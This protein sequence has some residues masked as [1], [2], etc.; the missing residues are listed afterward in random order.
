MIEAI[1]YCAI[2]FL[3][4]TLLA[5]L[6][7]PAVWRRAVRLT[8][9]RIEGAIPVSIA[10][11][12]ADK[13]E[14]RALFA[15]G[16]RRLEME[17]ERQQA[18]TAAQYGEI[19]RQAEALRLRQD[20]I[21]RLSTELD[22]LQTEHASVS[23]H[24]DHLLA[25]LET[26]TSALEE[27]RAALL[28]TRAELARTRDAFEDTRSREEGLQ[29]EHVAL[30]TLR[31]TLKDRIHELDRQLVAANAHLASERETV[32][33]TGESLATELRRNHAMKDELAK[34]QDALTRAQ[35]ERA[36]LQERI[37]RLTALAAAVPPAANGAAANGTEAAALLREHISD[38]AAGV[39]HLTARL[40][41]P[42]SKIEALL[43]EHTRVPGAPP[44]LADRILDLK[45][46]AERAETERAEA[47]APAV[48]PA[49]AV[50]EAVAAEE[51]RPQGR[52]AAG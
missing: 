23:T 43:A 4:A 39:A 28:H 13:D 35:E 9:K 32:R 25:E 46:A 24:R 15:V 44:S 6:T 41:G 30:T 5:L 29:I 48:S 31:D 37:E 40:E 8:R 42:G 22:A 19:V 50:I 36:A 21:D 18:R 7:L 33:T 49:P 34:V 17:V 26:T 38:I 2:G 3:A 47:E 27:A 45:A 51:A 10:E 14:Q 52:A 20:T 1:M 16:I 12:Q 11:V